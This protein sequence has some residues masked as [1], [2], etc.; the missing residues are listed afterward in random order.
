[1]FI[2]VIIFIIETKFLFLFIIPYINRLFFKFA[3]V[4]DNNNIGFEGAKALADALKLN[5]NLL[6]LDLRTFL[7]L[8]IQIIITIIRSEL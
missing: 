5:E 8:F 1:M 2:L 6:E 3:F 4:L 7:Q